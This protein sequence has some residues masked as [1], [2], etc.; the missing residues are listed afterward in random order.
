VGGKKRTPA[1][2][3]ASMN[4]AWIAALL[5]P[6]D[7]AIVNRYID[8]RRALDMFLHQNG[9][10][11]EELD[12]VKEEI[13]AAHRLVNFDGKKALNLLSLGDAR[14]GL[15]IVKRA[16]KEEDW[17]GVLRSGLGVMERAAKKEAVYNKDV[18]DVR[19]TL[20]AYL[21]EDGHKTEAVHECKNARVAY[22]A[23]LKAYQAKK[24]HAQ[25]K[26]VDDKNIDEINKD[27]KEIEKALG[28]LA[29]CGTQ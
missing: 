5:E 26:T 6:K 21:A 23:A 9:R 3:V 25:G 4:A 13:A 19:K 11:E 16:R 7:D 22:Q 8:S 17:E 14:F 1:A 28:E 18:G 20:S 27:V 10:L 2:L 24:G 29:E 12:G 15:G